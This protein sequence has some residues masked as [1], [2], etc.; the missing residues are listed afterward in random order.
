MAGMH[1]RGGG[2]APGGKRAGPTIYELHSHGKRRSAREIPRLVAAGIGIC[3]RAGRRELI[4]LGVLELLSGAG[5]RGGGGG[6]GGG[7][8]AGAQSVFA[9]GGRGGQGGGGIGRR[10]EQRVAECG[11]V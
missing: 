9:D 3:W 1:G 5:V 11:A 2:R 6:G 10:V 4:T 7:G 8:A